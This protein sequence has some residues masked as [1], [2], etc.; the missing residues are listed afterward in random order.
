M[1]R[2]G[3]ITRRA[4]MVGA[5]ALAG[6]V[7]FGTWAVRRP[8]ANPLKDGLAEGEATFNPWVI[9][10]PER[11][12]LIT[13]HADLGQGATSMQALLIAEEMDLGMDGFET[14]FGPPSPAYWN[15]ALSDESAPFR[16]TDRSLM[17][18]T[19][20]DV[21]SGAIKMLG[22]QVT[23]GSSSVPDSWEKLRVAGAVARETLKE[24]AAKEA[25]VARADLST[26]AGAVILPGGER[27]PYTALAARAAVMEPVTDVALKAPSEWRLIGTP[28]QRLDIVAKSTGTQEYGI[29]VT[30]PGMVHAAVRLSPTRAGLASYDAS[31]AEAMPGV[32]HVLEIGGGLAVVA[33]NSWTA[34][35]AAHAV[36]CEWEAAPYPAEQE[37][38]WAALSEAF[39]EDLLDKEWR[40]DGDVEAAPDGAET[41]EAEYRAPYVAH[42]PLEPL[43][44]TALMEDGTLKIWA[45]HQM[46][47][48][49]QDVA[50]EAAD[51]SAEDVIFHNV[52]AGGSFGHRL[53]FENIRAVAEIA[54]QVPG[55]P[56]KLTFSR[57]E[58][59]ALDFP[60]QIA[61]AR[62]RGAI[63]DGRIDVLDVQIA[64]P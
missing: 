5:A 56:V 21:M 19:V 29:D 53:E 32:T 18:E 17:A 34:M 54:A 38:H 43:N 52:A 15:R 64:A 1:S 9:V 44:A 24:A 60:R 41:I 59:F 6:G 30:L 57:E 25:G 27:R 55:T 2:A 11:I 20:R 7:A 37:G 16:S 10:G 46:P 3:R 22:V 45:A 42:Q 50:A 62:A 47:R 26:E 51:V 36:T 14:A 61:M 12:T 40:H 48:F 39:T 33:N 28:M 4:L 49:L 8:D 35:K 31:A 23:G 13:P 58:D 63:R